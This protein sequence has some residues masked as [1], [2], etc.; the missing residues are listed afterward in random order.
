MHPACIS[1]ATFI[2]LSFPNAVL[3]R[4]DI[5]PSPT[6]SPSPSSIEPS[7]T[8]SNRIFIDEWYDG[9]THFMTKEVHGFDSYFAP[10]SLEKKIDNFDYFFGDEDWE[11]E[12]RVPWFKIRGSVE[13]KEGGKF[14]FHQRFRYS[15]PLPILKKRLHMIF[16]SDAD[17][18]LE[19]DPEYEDTEEDENLSTGFKYFF[20][21][22]FKHIDTSINVG[23]R[24]KGNVIK[25]QF[26][27]VAYVKPRMKWSYSVGPCNYGV[28]E[29]LFW[30]SDDGFGESTRFDFDWLA[31]NRWL[32]KSGTGAEWSE[33]SLGVNLDQSFVVQYLD[34]SLHHSD[35][36]A[37]SLEWS[38]NA[39]TWTSFEADKHVL[40][41]RLR[42]SIWR[43]WLRVE[44][45]PRLTW[46]RVNKEE[47]G[48]YWRNSSPSI[49]LALEILFED[50]RVK[51]GQK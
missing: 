20:K 5:T 50:Q 25:L 13:W 27:P 9:I 18:D 4:D 10:E 37:A 3:P 46:E 48:S 43:S 23:A 21:N 26:D 40:A 7:A 12:I 17:D 31:S 29:Y 39:H 2:V 47:G 51:A 24:M 49:V 34:Q 41:L 32:F 30:Y 11:N 35:N 6:P 38:T 45:S 19:S 44:V 28:T 36:F 1:I 22:I 16:G 8:P 42:H 33:T 14:V 15:I